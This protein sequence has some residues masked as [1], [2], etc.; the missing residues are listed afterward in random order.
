L[1]NLYKI[2]LTKK[3]KLIKKGRNHPFAK[4]DKVSTKNRKSKLLIGNKFG[5]TATNIIRQRIVAIIE[6]RRG[7]PSLKML[8]SKPN[9]AH[10]GI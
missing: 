10:R 5:L 9:E 7:L 2:V 3:R 8:I 6:K 4:F 1:E